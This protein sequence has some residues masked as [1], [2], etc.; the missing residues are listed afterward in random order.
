MDGCAEGI[1]RMKN[2]W[3]YSPGFFD[4]DE[5]E[6]LKLKKAWVYTIHKFSLNLLKIQKYFY[7]KNKFTVIDFT[8][9]EVPEKRNSHDNAVLLCL[10]LSNGNFVA[11]RYH[12]TQHLTLDY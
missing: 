4:T 9:R 10:K 7:E 5:K 8:I 2:Y 6:V 12:N 1:G 3:A 11:K